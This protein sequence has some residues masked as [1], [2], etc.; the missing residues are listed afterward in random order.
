MKFGIDYKPQT[1][2]VIEADEIRLLVG[3]INR[4][5]GGCNDCPSI[6]YGEEV[7]LL[8]NIKDDAKLIDLIDLYE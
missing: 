8:G 2:D 1:G 6:E 7:N 5:G 4:L 3:D